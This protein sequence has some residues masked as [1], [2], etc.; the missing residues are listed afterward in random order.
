[1]SERVLGDVGTR[2]VWENDRVRIWEM[3][4]EPGDRSA[5]HEHTLD[6]VLIPLAGDRIGVEVEPDTAGRYRE[7]GDFPVPIGKAQ[8]IERGGVETAVNTG[9]ETY[10]EVL[11]ELKD[12]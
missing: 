1:M 10:R 5:V 11:I 12:P 3:V 7:S 9:T 4:L 6:Y 8:F 2:L